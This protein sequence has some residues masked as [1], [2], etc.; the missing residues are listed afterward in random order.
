MQK[1]HSI[2]FNKNKH[3]QVV[4]KKCTKIVQSLMVLGIYGYH[5]FPCYFYNLRCFWRFLGGWHAMCLSC[6][7]VLMNDNRLKKGGKKMAKHKLRDFCASCCENTNLHEGG[8]YD[9][10][11]MT[12]PGCGH[13]YFEVITDARNIEEYLELIGF[14]E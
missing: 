4:L 2:I 12:C 9:P 1:S 14:E 8:K 3:L 13:D 10:D 11:F 7:A 5:Y 6:I